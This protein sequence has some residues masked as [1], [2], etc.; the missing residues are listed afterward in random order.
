M[1]H[2]IGRLFLAV[3]AL[4]LSGG[5]PALAHPHIFVDSSAEI[6]FDSDGRFVEI[7]HRWSFD[8]AF[9][10][11]VIQGLDTDNDG[12]ITPTELLDLAS[13][14]LLGLSAFD[15]YT[16]AGEDPTDLIL[17]PLPGARMHM[18]GGRVVF[19]FSVVPVSPYAIGRTLEI[20]V[21]DPDYYVAFSFPETGGAKLV[22]PPLGCS[23]ESHAPKPLDPADAQRLA[24]VGADIVALPSEL[25]ALVRDQ[26]N[27]ILVHCPLSA[28]PDAT[29]APEP[30]TALDAI[31]AATRPVA[32]PFGG[33]P[34]ERNLPMPRTGFF[35]W[36]NEQQKGFYMAMSDGLAAFRN[37][38]SA[39]LILGLLSFLYGVF[40]AAGPGHGKVVVT[41]YLLAGERQLKSGIALSFASALMQSL[42]AIAF[43]LI[44]AAALKMTSMAMST[45]AWSIEV[46]S[47]ALIIALGLW[48]LFRK[49][50]GA[51]HVHADHGHD[52]VHHDHQHGTHGHHH[53]V[54]PKRGQNLKE[55]LG[56][57]LAVGLRPCSGALVVL[58]FALSQ[59][60]LLA[61]IAA[62][63]LMGLGTAL[64]VSLLAILAV[65]AKVLALRIGS[66]AERAERV[67]SAF[68]IFG[69]LLLTAFGG[70]MLAAS[71]M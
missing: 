32:A 57:I 33:P 42:T 35:G 4:F 10:S 40:H 47:Y 30:T 53:V 27:I 52:H 25:K 39:F 15:Y 16:F 22:N 24:T 9:S 5:A 26:A 50:T 64:T 20:E 3:F 45:A 29:A 60:V 38:G 8:E 34:P 70:V 14:N 63:L 17:R 19:E 51:G 67:V 66:G 6:V 36:I 41:S 59:G 21:S 62:V 44:A 48:L 43:V 2:L 54:V 13:E 31:D 12:E 58:V 56:L 18:E 71:L 37:D 7:R 68:E 49:L 1:R 69:A 65:G 23:V 11:W 28:S 61:G 46:L 55:A